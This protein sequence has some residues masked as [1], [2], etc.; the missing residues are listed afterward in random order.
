MANVMGFPMRI[1][2]GRGSVRELPQEL[3]RA[4]AK[5]KVLVVTDAGIL[6]AGLLRHVLPALQ[7]AGLAAQPFTEVP[8][9]P[10]EKHAEAA[11]QA[12][13]SA[14]AD[15]LVAFGGGAAIDVARAAALL[16]GHAP[17]FSAYA[18]ADGEAKVTG[19]VPPWVAVPTVAGSGSEASSAA[20]L[21]VDG[22]KAT[23][24]ARRLHASAAILD[25][26]LT[27][28]LPPLPTAAGGMA[29][30]AHCLEALLAQGDHPI[31]DALALEGLRRAGA[32]IVKATKNGKDL[33][34]RAELLLAAAF[35]AIAAEKGQ[36]PCR[37]LAHAL[38]AEAQTPHGLA[39]ALVLP[40]VAAFDKM[41][42]EEKLAAAAA[43]LG[44]DPRAPAAERAAACAGLLD[45]L[46]AQCGLPRKLGQAGVRREQLPQLVERA[47]ADGAHAQGPRA[48]G[49]LEFERILGEAF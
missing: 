8:L 2:H 5:A 28:G 43:A 17:P 34:A 19:T 49:E 1:V 13:Q 38:A 45:Q 6:K 42:A 46:R 14:G 33:D 31:A 7:Q 27:A 26:E 18:Q 15:A 16:V 9:H 25:A 23:V 36:G 21:M 47:A 37:S 41:A 39:C 32:A 44:H 11:A 35:G 48:C 10:G 30:L 22:A 40:Q 24:R 3:K 29:A 12:F 4:G 20:V